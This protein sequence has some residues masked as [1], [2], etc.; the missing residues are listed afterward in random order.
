MGYNVEVNRRPLSKSGKS[1][2]ND[3]LWVEA[4]I[5]KRMLGKTALID[6]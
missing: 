4:A 6:S 5:A 3:R 2:L 1:T